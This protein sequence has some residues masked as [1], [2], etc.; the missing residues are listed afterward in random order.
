MAAAPK[1][2]RSVAAAIGKN[3][4]VLP[5][6]QFHCRVGIYVRS[7]TDREI[8]RL[9]CEFQCFGFLTAEL[10][11]CGDNQNSAEIEKIAEL[12]KAVPGIK[13]LNNQLEVK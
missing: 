12:A 10:I 8:A 1:A 7:R 9:Y 13:T 5:G 4:I 6:N 3:T 2:H 11:V